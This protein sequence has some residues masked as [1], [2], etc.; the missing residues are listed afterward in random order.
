MSRR[1]SIIIVLVLLSGTFIR[2]GGKDL[3]SL[4]SLWRNYTINMEFDSVI[5]SGKEFFHSADSSGD[6]YE[7]CASGLYVAQ[8]YLSKS[9]YDSVFFWLSLVENDVETLSDSQMKIILYNVK[10]ILS[11][12]LEVDYAACF[13]YLD[14]ALSIA[15]ETASE[16]SER[17]ILCN[18]AGIY[19]S[20]QDTTGLRYAVQAYDLSKKAGDIHT[21]PAAIVYIIR[22]NILKGDYNLAE[23]Y[24]DELS[25]MY[26]E[27]HVPQYGYM[28]W[29]LTAEI[30][31]HRGDVPEADRC[32]EKAMELSDSVTYPTRISGY[33]DYGTFLLHNDRPVD[34]ERVLLHGLS[35]SREKGHFE[36]MSDYL[37][38]LS[39][40][41]DYLGDKEKAYD[42]YQQYHVFERQNSNNERK[43]N[44]LRMMYQTLMHEKE[45]SLK[46]LA[47]MRTQRRNILVG[48]LS[49]VLTVILVSVCVLYRRKNRMY[50]QLVENHYK[51]SQALSVRIQDAEDAPECDLKDAD[52]ALYRRIEGLMKNEGLYRRSDISLEMIADRLETN[53]TYISNAINIKSGKSFYNYINSYRISEAL[54]V[55]SD[56]HN[57]IPLKALCE[58]LG[59]N[60]MSTFYRAFQKET[61]VPPSAY[62]EQIRRIKL[63]S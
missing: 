31:S 19:N 42:Y 26:R 1:I 4:V 50:R 47:L 48:S 9:Q 23:K 5:T 25:S 52:E 45:I 10:A 40:V 58:D 6:M 11:L 24:V 38:R 33:L 39:E 20:I 30:M 60:S 14:K 49:L 59:F 32:Y 35:V 29:L 21:L 63:S 7:R 37:L 13:E 53:R 27:I 3:D 12:S 54:H 57:D 43:F 61:G 34:A 41:Y 51:L 56:E 55:L 36:S 62:R 28:V 44:Q 18:I 2:I 16:E 46:D 17:S 22:M 15:H 8:A